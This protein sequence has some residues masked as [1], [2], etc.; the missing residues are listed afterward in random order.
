MGASILR[1]AIRSCVCSG[2]AKG[3]QK[4]F[5]FL[6]EGLCFFFFIALF[7]PAKRDPI[8]SLVGMLDGPR[9]RA[10]FTQ[11]GRQ[12]AAYITGGM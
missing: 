7:P 9:L 12:A 5:K 8:K 11:A 1:E 2:K 6:L 4:S 10:S 3:L